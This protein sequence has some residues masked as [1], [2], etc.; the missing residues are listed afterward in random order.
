MDLTLF[1]ACDTLAPAKRQA[2]RQAQQTANL[3]SADARQWDGHVVTMETGSWL[4]GRLY[5]IHKAMQS[6]ER[7]K[8][9]EEEEERGKKE[10]IPAKTKGDTLPRS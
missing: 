8:K 4:G 1:P 5:H 2:W 9:E 7:E 6:G 3:W 10:Q